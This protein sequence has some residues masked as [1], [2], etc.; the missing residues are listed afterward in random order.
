[1]ADLHS[2]LSLSLAPGLGPTL[3]QRLL[4]VFADPATVLTASVKDLAQVPGIGPRLAGKLTR[5]QLAPAADRQIELAQRHGAAILHLGL[6]EY[7]EQLRH[8]HRPPLILFVKGDPKW[9]SEPGVAIVG[10]RAATSYGRKMAA[11]LGRELAG[12]GLVVISGVALGVDGAAHS[13]ALSRGRTVGVLGCGLDV[14][15]PRQHGRL[16]G[17]IAASGAL[18]SEYPFGTRPEPFRFPAR[19]RIISGLSRGVVVVE[20]GSRSGSLITARLALEQGRDVFAVPGRVDSGKSSGAHRLLQEGARLVAGSADVLFELAGL[21]SCPDNDETEQWQLL[22]DEK[23]IHDLLD[24]YGL[25]IDEI[26]QLSGMRPEKVAEILLV[27]ELKGAVESQPG[28]IYMSCDP[29]PQAGKT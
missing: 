5:E 3:L 19:N 8:I 25:G 1:M 11:E 14:V 9:L 22:G 21:D 10:S 23:K 15:Y 2:W 7:P 20:A 29:A 4:A 27:L 17:E 28:N 18:V 24:I 13:G 12:A 16:Y 6:A 26:I